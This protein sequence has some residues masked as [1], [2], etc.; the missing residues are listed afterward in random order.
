MHVLC[1][2][3]AQHSAPEPSGTCG[4]Y[5]GGSHVSREGKWDDAAA[6]RGY[7]SGIIWRVR[8]LLC[9][10]S[11]NDDRTAER[12]SLV[13]GIKSQQEWDPEVVVQIRGVVERQG[14]FAA[15]LS[16]AGGNLEPGPPLELI[17]PVPKGGEELG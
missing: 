2:V 9:I 17:W 13:Q 12:S 11:R 8:C 14:C 3:R 4:C 6:W 1:L 10:R 7:S 16:R 5:L 15:C